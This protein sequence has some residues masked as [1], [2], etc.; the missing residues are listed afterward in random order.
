MHVQA[1]YG[2]DMPLTA[3]RTKHCCLIMGMIVRR[4]FSAT[5]DMKTAIINELSIGMS[6]FDNSNCSSIW[7]RVCMVARRVGGDSRGWIQG[8]MMWACPWPLACLLPHRPLNFSFNCSSWD[9]VYLIVSKPY[10][11]SAL[12]YCCALSFIDAWSEIATFAW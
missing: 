6:A 8:C 11:T 5:G 10:T 4:L 9:L 7:M 12:L 2:R 1:R 3:C